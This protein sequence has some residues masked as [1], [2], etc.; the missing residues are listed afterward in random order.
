MTSRRGRRDK[1]S[2]PQPGPISR[3]KAEELLTRWQRQTTSIAVLVDANVFKMSFK[4][5]VRMVKTGKEIFLGKNS[6]AECP[7][8]DDECPLYIDT[9]DATF[10]FED[11]PATIPPEM[12][13]TI[14]SEFMSSVA[15]HLPGGIDCLIIQLF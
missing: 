5:Y 8:P 4:G 9:S 10:S 7:L 15:I 12:Q 13:G 1:M 14:V 3:A 6:N 11:Q 2:S